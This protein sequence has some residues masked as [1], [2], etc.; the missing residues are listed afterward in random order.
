MFIPSTRMAFHRKYF[1]R[2]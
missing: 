1:A 2:F